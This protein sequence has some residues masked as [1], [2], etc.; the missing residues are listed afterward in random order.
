MKKAVIYKK[1][2]NKVVEC[3]ACSWYCKIPENMVGLCATRYNMGGNLYSLVYGRPVG[4]AIDPVEKKPLYHFLPGSKI[5]SFGTVGC[6]FGC[7]FCQNFEMSQTNKNVIKNIKNKKYLKKTLDKIID[8][9]SSQMSPIQIIKL[10]LKN[11]VQGIAYTYNE[12]AIFVEFAYETAKLAKRYGLKNIYVSNGFESPEAFS[13][14][15]KYLD[16]INID[17]KSFRNEF[18]NKICFSKIE[19]VLKNIKIF[20]KSGIETEITTLIIPTL[21]DSLEELQDIAKFLASISK[22]IPWHISAFYPAYKMISFPP[23]PHETLDKAYKI[24]LDQG[25]KYIYQ[26]N[27]YNPE[28]SSTFCPKCKILLIKRENYDVSIEKID[29]KNGRCLNCHEKIYGIWH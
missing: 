6:N 24:G 7:L 5:L 11:Q 15:K 19:P 29:L 28:K 2:S 13:Y 25:L 1:L 27:V 16:A 8:Q 10:A 22:D 26:G 18:Y 9:F 23:T 17:L 12:P 14:I 21:N 20:F 4:L 3:L